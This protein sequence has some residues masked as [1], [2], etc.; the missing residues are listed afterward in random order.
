MLIKCEDCGH[1]MS[2]KAKAC[3][4][5]GCPNPRIEEKKDG[6][7]I[8]IGYIPNGPEVIDTSRA[9]APRFFL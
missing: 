5:C 6:K 8:V 9:I 1:E 3:P 2:D 4:N 7:K